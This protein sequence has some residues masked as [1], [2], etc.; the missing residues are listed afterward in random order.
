M[1]TNTPANENRTDSEP[2][3]HVEAFQETPT[4]A[5]IRL[6]S[7]GDRGDPDGWTSA[8]EVV[9]PDE[10]VTTLYADDGPQSGMIATQVY[11]RTI[12][13]YAELEGADE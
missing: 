4:G 1:S 3:D 13:V 11:N 9:A 8:V 12:D 6:R 2:F 7:Y 5:V 10:H